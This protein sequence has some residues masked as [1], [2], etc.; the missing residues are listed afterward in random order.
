MPITPGRRHEP[1]TQGFFHDE[2]FDF[3]TRNVLG[4]S[5]YGAADPGEV[6]A[7]LALVADGDHDAWATAWRNLGGRVLAGADEQL[8]AGH[9]VSACGSYLRAATYLGQATNALVG[10][11]H[12]EELLSAF[13]D[14]R[15]AWASYLANAAFAAEAVE[16]PYEGASLPGWIVR[17]AGDVVARRTLVLTNGSDGSIS[18]LWCSGGV[19][20][21]ERGYTVLLYDG[22][23]QQSMLFE[24][25]TFFRPDWEAVLTPVIDFA[26]TRPEVDGSRIGLYAI[27]QGGYWLPRALTAEHRARAAIA[28]PGVVDV[29]TSWTGHLPSPMRHLLAEGKGESF[30]EDMRVGMRFSHD[31][32]RMWSYRAA[33]YGQTSPFAT[34]SAVEQYCLGDAASAITTPL[35][36]TAPE[37]EQFWPGQSQSLV[38]AVAGATLLPFTEAEGANLHCQPMARALTDQRMLDWLD[39]R[40]A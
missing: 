38:N 30:D 21:L 40:L 18:D 39:E 12:D 28:D 32:A 22:P 11:D 24:R 19:A 16:I 25:K 15:R 26:L 7:A 3:E 6:L 34:M 35:L 31:L 4:R 20:A 37:G 33:P 27:S 5:V 8:V 13:H 10:T 17:P 2:G 23:G 29:S 9:R 36:V 14:H 1:F